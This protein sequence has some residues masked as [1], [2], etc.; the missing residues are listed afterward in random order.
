MQKFSTLGLITAAAAISFLCATA[1][2][3][4]DSSGR[5]VIVV[6]ESR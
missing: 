4:D 3:G 6:A 1:V 5:D 2:H